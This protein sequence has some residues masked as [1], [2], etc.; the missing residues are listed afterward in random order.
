MFS[1]FSQVTVSEV[2]AL[3]DKCPSKSSLRDPIP[4]FLL[5]EFSDILVHPITNIINLSLSSGIFPDEMKLAFVTPLLKKSD[6][7]PNKLCNYRPVSNLSF[8]SKLVE[9]VCVKQIMSHLQS[10]NL[11]VPVQSAY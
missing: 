2:A 7:D 5:K 9:R 8:L 3:L 1:S 4:T 6:L 11:L 10:S